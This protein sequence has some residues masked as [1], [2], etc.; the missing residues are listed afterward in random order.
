MSSNPAAVNAGV[1]RSRQPLQPLRSS[2]DAL[3]GG[4]GSTGDLANRPAI[5]SAKT[6]P[7]TK[8][9]GYA[10]SMPIGGGFNPLHDAAEDDNQGFERVAPNGGRKGSFDA[11]ATSPSKGQATIVKRPVVQ[12]SQSSGPLETADSV[13][14]PTINASAISAIA[15]SPGK[16]QPSGGQGKEVT[17][18]AS[19][20][21]KGFS[22]FLQNLG[23]DSSNKKQEKSQSGN[24]LAESGSN[25]PK[26]K[27]KS[28]NPFSSMKSSG[29]ASGGPPKISGPVII[30]IPDNPMV[31]SVMATQQQQ[32][33]QQQPAAAINNSAHSL[34]NTGPIAA[35][36][37]LQTPLQLS[38]TPAAPSSL[39]QVEEAQ[40]GSLQPS[41]SIRKKE[42][43]S[44]GH[45]LNRAGPPPLNVATAHGKTASSTEPMSPTTASQAIGVSAPQPP[46]PPPPSFYQ[47]LAQ[48]ANSNISTKIVE[49]KSDS[50]KRIER[51]EEQVKQCKD[52]IDTLVADNQLL[53]KRLNEMSSLLDTVAASASTKVPTLTTTVTA[54]T[55]PEEQDLQ[56]LNKLRHT[57]P[58][59]SR[60]STVRTSSNQSNNSSAQ[61]LPAPIAHTNLK[62]AWSATGDE[63]NRQQQDKE[64]DKPKETKETKDE[65]V[66]DMALLKTEP[67]IELDA[68]ELPDLALKLD[69]AQ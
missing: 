20:S 38:S 55:I 33:P 18:V 3:G 67:I 29:K 54:S 13:V 19:P 37:P 35:S 36:L 11:R 4:S 45:N 43:T 69:L 56:P 61:I 17:S 7:T 64:Q 53:H 65:V 63:D 39:V 58:E 32:Q 34:L 1:P 41:D 44:S 31:N 24:P 48:Q 68:I 52:L 25:T 28:F 26:E 42:K 46:P 62:N 60:Q 47:N 8:T 59:V 12:T 14:S 2:Q 6:K 22:S 9:T 40:P 30:S 21:K 50:K 27:R 15:T 16:A 5:P 23:M 10:A 57:N 51:L 66:K 49:P